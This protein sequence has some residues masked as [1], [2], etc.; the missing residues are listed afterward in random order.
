MSGS[1]HSAGREAVEILAVV[2]V[3]GIVV[4]LIEMAIAFSGSPAMEVP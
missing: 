4:G 2:V 1:R 3:I